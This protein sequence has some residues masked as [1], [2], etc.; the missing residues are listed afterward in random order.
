MILILARCSYSGDTVNTA[1]RMESNGEGGRIHMSE[2]TANLLIDANKGYWVEKRAD[3]V[4][5]KGKGELQ[6][7]WVVRQQIAEKAGSE[8]SFGESSNASLN[9]DMFVHASVID[10][11]TKRLIQ[12][13]LQRFSFL[14]REI[15]AR[16]SDETSR[17]VLEDEFSSSTAAT[18]MTGTL[19][20]EE[21]KEVIH[22]TASASAPGR[23]VKN[24]KHVILDATV[25]S[26]LE[27]YITLIAE[28]YEN[29][30]F[31]K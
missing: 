9:A 5:A 25:S 8:T 29:N 31:H 18:S 14:L 7:Y 6:T 4:K 20:F 19:P 3:K 22:L 1:S 2:E 24:P 27:E 12:W 13:N 16:R 23:M 11:K 28:M 21:V 10:A 30:A 15:A 26:Q 17:P